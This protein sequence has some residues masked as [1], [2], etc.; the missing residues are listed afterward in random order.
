MCYCIIT[1]YVSVF[2]YRLIENQNCQN[3]TRSLKQE[4]ALIVGSVIFY[5]ES[6]DRPLY[7][8]TL[9]VA[10]NIASTVDTTFT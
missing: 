7:E 6:G 8:S 10:L 1:T 4:N 2:H 9:K 3:H 5:M